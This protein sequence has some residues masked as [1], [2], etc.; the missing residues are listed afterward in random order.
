VTCGLLECET[1]GLTLASSSFVRAVTPPRR[2]TAQA[3]FCASDMPCRQAGNP[4][5]IRRHFDPSKT[6][7]GTSRH[8]RAAACIAVSF[9][10]CPRVGR[11]RTTHLTHVFVPDYSSRRTAMQPQRGSR[12]LLGCF[13]LTTGYQ[14]DWTPQRLTHRRMLHWIIA[15]VDALGYRATIITVHKGHAPPDWRTSLHVCNVSPRQAAFS[16]RDGRKAVCRV[17]GGSRRSI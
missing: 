10:A 2:I 15:P 6:G 1:P 4:I 16:W 5:Q 9:S 7:N 3:S 17:Y 12:L 14:S 13:M 8:C 11:E